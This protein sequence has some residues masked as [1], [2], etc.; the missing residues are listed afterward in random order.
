MQLL[1]GLSSVSV[2]WDEQNLVS[3]A[4]LVPVMALAD[5]AGLKDLGDTHVKLPTDKGAHAGLKI[6]S[7][8]AGMVAGAD[9]IDD[10]VLLK[11]G[12][13]GKLFGSAYAPSTLGSFLR[14]FT[15]GHVRQLDAVSSRVLVNLNT[16]TPLTTSNTSNTAGTGYAFADFDDSIVEVYGHAKQGAQYGYSGVRGLNMM[17][18]TLT[19]Q[20][21]A[22]VVVGQRLRRGACGSPRGA[23]KF[24]ADA[25]SPVLARFDSAFY[26]SLVIKAVLKAGA[27]YSV[28][29]KMNANVKKAVALIEEKA[30]KPITY[31]TPVLDKETNTL[32]SKAEVA[33]IDFTAFTSKGKK[34]QVDTRLVVRRVPELNPAHLKKISD[35]QTTLFTP[36]RYHG[37]ITN[38]T[39]DTVTADKTHRH[40]AI[41]EQVN[42]DLKDSALNHMPSGVFNANAAWLILAVMALNLTRA[43]ATLTTIDQPDNPLVKARTGSIRTKII[44]IPARIATSARK[45]V[46]HL[47]DNWPWQQP[48]TSIFN[49]THHRHKTG[50]SP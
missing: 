4:G 33:E 41:I 42:A 10:M 13:L 47:P 2:S 45:I 17:L 29:A 48:F 18:G 6:S 37:F 34:H 3:C 26:N 44:N 20:G 11:H 14:T 19:T 38:T 12:G 15:F 35:D 40:H 5:K 8:V 25:L 36:H 30:W 46:L 7:L 9:C 24:I 32:I 1:H 31:S 49:H 28:T 21:R 27:H 22:P 39:L 23:A 50:I 16:L 43:T